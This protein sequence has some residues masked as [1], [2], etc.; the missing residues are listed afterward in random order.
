MDYTKRFDGKGE[1]YAKARPKYAKELF[2]FLKNSLKIEADSVFADVGSGTGI[3]TA[4]LIDCGYKVYAVE[5]NDDMRVKAEEKLRGT[6][7]FVSVR[8]SADDTTLPDGSVD[9]VTA[10]QAFHWF[11]PTAFGRECRRILKPRGKVVIAYN[12]HKPG[13]E[14]TKTL[15]ELYYKYNPEFHGF[16]NGMSDEKCRSFFGGKCNVF[17]TDNTQVYD[18]RGYV[19]RVLSSSYSLKEGDAEFPEYL[20]AINGIFDVFAEDGYISVPI[21][22]IAYIG[23][24]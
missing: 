7:N 16:S 9:C 12:A 5:P 14:Y 22:T 15:K 17:C 13:E 10:A 23:E 21:E 18:C 1:I 24:I 20:A 11:D 2:D 4:Q 3:F 19:D 6:A 8:G